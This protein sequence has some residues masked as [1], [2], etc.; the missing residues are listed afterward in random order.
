MMSQPH[1]AVSG[2]VSL[3]A[4]VARAERR[5]RARQLV[6]CLCT[7]WTVLVTLGGSLHAAAPDEYRIGPRDVVEVLVWGQPELSGKYTLRSDGAF[8]FPLVGDVKVAGLTASEVEARLRQLLGDGFLTSPQVTAKVIEFNSQRVF[9]VGEVGKG[10]E[11]KL[12][13]SLTLL[14]ALS[15][16]GGVEQTAGTDV[17]VLR[18]SGESQSTGPLAVGQPGVQELARV[19]LDDLQAG[20]AKDNV[21]LNDGDTIFVPKAEVV[22]VTGEVLKPGPLTYEHGLTVLEA[23][24]LAGGTTKLGSNKAR[25]IRIVDGQ[26]KELKTKLTDLLQPG[27]IVRVPTRLF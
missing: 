6:I 7:A 23:I 8:E 16:A 17:V 25:I 24:S 27:D 26:Q 14:E 21:V 22:Y 2:F 3:I 4:T 19:S 18:Q 20:R 9:V 11:V 13:G 15:Q 1:G 10:G 12:T 5:R